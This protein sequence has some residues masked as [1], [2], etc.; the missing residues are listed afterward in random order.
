M[1]SVLLCTVCFF[2]CGDRPLHRIMMA[3]TLAASGHLETASY[4]LA[5][6]RSLDI[7]NIHYHL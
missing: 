6:S 3:V 5:D 4:R 2:R 1:N 7:Y